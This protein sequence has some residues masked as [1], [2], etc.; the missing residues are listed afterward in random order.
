MNVLLIQ[1]VVHFIHFFEVIHQFLSYYFITWVV[2]AVLI[3]AKNI[4]LLFDLSL[5]LVFLVF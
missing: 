4:V 2:H 3:L 1:V 5:V